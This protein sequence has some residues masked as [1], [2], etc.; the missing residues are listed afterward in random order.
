MHFG[1]CNA[2]AM[3]QGA[4][5]FVLSGLLWSKALCYLDDAVTL[6]DDFD[7]AMA[8]LHEVF[9]CFRTHDLKMKPKK[10]VLFQEDV[11]YL[12]HLV[13]RHWVTLRPDHVEI[14]REWP[15][16]TKKKQLQSFL[17]F[18]NYHR[19]F[20]KDYSVI[21]NELQMLVTKSKAVPIQLTKCHLDVIQTLKE[22]LSNAAI[23]PFPNPEC[24]FVIDCDASETTIGCELSQVVDVKECVISYGSFSLTPA[25]CKYCTTH[26]ELLTVVRFTR[27]FRHYLLDRQFVC[28]TD[29]N[30][31]TWLISFKNTEGQLARW[32]EELVQF[33]MVVVVHRTGKL[34]VKADAL[35]RIPDTG[36]YCPN[37]HA[38][39][40]LS[41]LPYYSRLNPCKF[42]TTTE[43][44]WARFEDK[45]DY[46][47]PLSVRCIQVDVPSGGADYWLSGYSKGDLR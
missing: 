17:G 16:P 2:P 38:G 23:F 4:M 47:V 15:V 24:T 21:V 22:K 19:E 35:S 27:Q 32:M 41:A 33:D 12:R 11:E 29:H 45:V 9:G 18:T 40:S 46:V 39:V 42:C 7:T 5:Q 28:R 36:G 34:H 1:L 30:S 8:N 31:L 20:I 44:R 25:Q 10:C 14:I 13:R 6:G 37:H 26:K 3:F 43:A